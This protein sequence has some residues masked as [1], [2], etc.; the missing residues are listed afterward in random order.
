MSVSPAKK[1]R[2]Q[3][4]LLVSK[5]WKGCCCTSISI[6]LT[7]SVFWLLMIFFK[8]TV[9][10]VMKPEGC[11]SPLSVSDA[12]FL[13]PFKNDFYKVTP[14]KWLK[15]QMEK[16]NGL[17]GPTS[18]PSSHTFLRTFLLHLIAS[19]ITVSFRPI[20]IRLWPRLFSGRCEWKDVSATKMAK[21][22][23][24]MF[25]WGPQMQ[26]FTAGQGLIMFQQQHKSTEPSNITL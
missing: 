7:I 21:Q 13:R 26:A 10:K 24:L 4:N 15:Q 18:P 2:I 12:S 16:R 20:C 14:S 17:I 3:K 19:E 11:W 1:R 22:P 23:L 25:L 8:L 9:L 6:H 5:I